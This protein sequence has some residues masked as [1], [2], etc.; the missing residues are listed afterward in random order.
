MTRLILLG[1]AVYLLLVGIGF[2]P[3]G[4]GRQNPLFIVL[5]IVF[6]ILS[7]VVRRRRPPRPG[8]RGG[9]EGEVGGTAPDP[10]SATYDY[11]LPLPK[12]LEGAIQT[13][14]ESNQGEAIR[15]V[16]EL[17]GVG[18]AEARHYVESLKPH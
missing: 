12:E 4:G 2:L 8:P 1:I 10:T 6:L 18:L 3:G 14:A 16:R 13:I 11:S 17:T 9:T 5:G 7:N 15:R